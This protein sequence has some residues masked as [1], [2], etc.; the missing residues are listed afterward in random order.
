MFGTGFANQV[1]APVAAG[2]PEFVGGAVRWGASVIAAHPV[3]WDVPFAAVQL[4]IGIGLLVPRSARHGA[5]SCDQQRRHRRTRVARP[6]PRRG[7]RLD[8][9]S[10][11]GRRDRAGRL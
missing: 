7:L 1:I 2:Q 10:R 8:N 5:G 3:A 6:A 9:R 11:N 4:L